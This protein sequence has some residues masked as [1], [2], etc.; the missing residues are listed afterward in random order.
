MLHLLDEMTDTHAE[1]AALVYHRYYEPF[2]AWAARALRPAVPSGTGPPPL[3]NNQAP[4][5]GRGAFGSRAR[6]WK[7]RGTPSSSRNG[8]TRRGPPPRF[9]A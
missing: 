2:I 1:Q 5:Q 3:P 7:P 9:S 8:T 4:S 6:A